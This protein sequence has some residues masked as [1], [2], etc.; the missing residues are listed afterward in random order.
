M[1]DFDFT[2]LQVGFEPTNQKIINLHSSTNSI[3]HD[4]TLFMKSSNDAIDKILQR[5]SKIEQR[6]SFI[7]DLFLKYKRLTRCQ[8]MEITKTGQSTA[9]NDLAVLIEIGF[10]VR[11]SP[12]KSPRTDFFEINSGI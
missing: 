9:T 11:R 5:G 3:T 8:V 4:N 2:H 1:E 7:K 12:T 6:R 10:I